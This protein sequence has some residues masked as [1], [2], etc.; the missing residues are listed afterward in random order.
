VRTRPYERE[1]SAANYATR[2]S[3]EASGVLSQRALTFESRLIF[4]I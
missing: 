4:T 1:L 2:P 3:S